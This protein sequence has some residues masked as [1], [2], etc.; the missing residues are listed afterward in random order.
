MRPAS[1]TRSLLAFGL[2]LLALVATVIGAALSQRHSRD[3]VLE[4][5]AGTD[6]R[7]ILDRLGES[8]AESRETKRQYLDTRDSR[9]LEL[10]QRQTAFLRG[11]VTRLS[12]TAGT[13]PGRAEQLARVREVTQQSIDRS[14]KILGIA[15]QGHWEKA[16]AMAREPAAPSTELAQL[17]RAHDEFIEQHRAGLETS[18]RTTLAWLLGGGAATLLA[19][20]LGLVLVNA[21]IARNKEEEEEKQ[22][23]VDFQ[24]R[25]AGMIGHDLR[26]PIGA[27][28]ASAQLVLRHRDKLA[29]GDARAMELIV[30]CARRVDELAGMLN[31]FTRARTGG[32]LPIQPRPSDLVAVVDEVLEEVRAA[33]PERTLERVLEGSE[34][35]AGLWDADRLEQVFENLVSNAI[36]YGDPQGTVR[37]I[38]SQ[39]EGRAHAT[40]ANQGPPLDEDVVAH[41]FEPFRRGS[42]SPPSKDG[43]GMGLFICREI[44]RAHGGTITANSANGWTRFELELPLRATATEALPAPSAP[45]H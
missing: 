9:L 35:P 34:R 18:Y 26:N 45:L 7:R 5:R 4:I 11:L 43:L 32:G 20:L 15:Q 44:V 10:Y 27:A 22:R 1:F 40:V 14:E 16:Q 2:G 36:K 23:L 6:Q 33:H 38:L 3:L 12:S 19:M 17:R 28:L 31:D 13:P 25:L 42:R 39:S 8:V 21:D 41:L 29:P 30:R 24:E 37:V